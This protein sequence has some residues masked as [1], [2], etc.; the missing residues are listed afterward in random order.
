MY[1]TGWGLLGL[2]SSYRS[3]RVTWV[4]AGMSSAVPC[5][6]ALS[7]EVITGS[8]GRERLTYLGRGVRAASS[9]KEGS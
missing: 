6:A 7:G 9:G 1:V 2:E 5:K 8:S 4:G 3:G